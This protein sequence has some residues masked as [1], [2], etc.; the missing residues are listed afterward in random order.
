MLRHPDNKYV[1][2]ILNNDRIIIREIYQKFQPGV[3]KY[4]K[5]NSG[6]YEDGK[7][8]FQTALSAIFMMVRKEDFKL[9]SSFSTLFYSVVRFTWLK[10]LRK[11]KRESALDNDRDYEADT[12]IAASMDQVEAYQLYKAHFDNLGG[13]CKEI[14]TLFFEKKSMKEIAGIMH[15][16]PAYAKKLKHKCKK[17]LIEK[18]EEDDRYWELKE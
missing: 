16:S 8:T 1:E 3:L 17:Q 7:D 4:V 11:Q 5:D 12:D 13:K 15:I 6:S 10:Q 2:G 18:I 14:L 9:T